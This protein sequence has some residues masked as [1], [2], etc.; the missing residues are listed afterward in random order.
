MAAGKS[1]PTR[2]IRSTAAPTAW[3]RTG[4]LPVPLG[5]GVAISTADS[6]LCIGGQTPT[7]NTAR[8]YRLRWSNGAVVID[9]LPSLPAAASNTMGALAGDTIYVAGGQST[10]ASLKAPRHLL[11][12]VVETS[13]GRLAGSAHLARRGPIPGRGR[14]HF[15]APS[16]WRV[17]RNSPAR[18][19]PPVGR[20]FLK[21]V[22]RYR[23]GQGW[24]RLPDL[25][26]ATSAGYAWMDGGDLIV[27]GGNDGEYADREFQMKDQHP[28]F[29][30]HIFRLTPGAKQW[31][32]A[33]KMPSSLVTSGLVRW[34]DEV[35]IA[36]GEDRPGHRSARVIA[37]KSQ[38]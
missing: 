15:Q 17:E 37:G 19:A 25:P 20:R 36:G 33:G 31:R 7:E 28:G 30:L 5:Y 8:V 27:M 26:A 21:D 38:H 6:L 18:P 23:P 1:G 4:T 13:G 10:P 14:R 2:S 35:V 3:K 11:V 22:Y 34:G 9:I 29:P 24:D 16:T 32:P 12:L